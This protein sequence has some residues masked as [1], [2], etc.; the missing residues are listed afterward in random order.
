MFEINGW[1][2][3]FLHNSSVGQLK[4]IKDVPIF[5]AIIQHGIN[6]IKSLKNLHLAAILPLGICKIASTRAANT[7]LPVV[8]A[9][10]S[11][12]NSG[13]TSRRKGQ[14]SLTRLAFRRSLHRYLT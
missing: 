12:K 9:R 2:T 3:V 11:W 6:F 13:V 4:F 8:L 10:Y 7:T 1:D 14:R 5:L